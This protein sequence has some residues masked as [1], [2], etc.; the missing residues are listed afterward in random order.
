[1]QSYTKAEIEA[2]LADIESDLVERKATW[3]GDAPEKGRQAVCTFANDLPGHGKPGL[4]VVGAMD[5]GRPSGQL[6]SD[7]LLQTLADIKTDGNTLPPPTILVQK[8]VLQG[9]EMAVVPVT[10]A[11]TPRCVAQVGGRFAAKAGF[12]LRFAGCSWIRM[13]AA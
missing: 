6:V 12:K 5:D 13:P 11:D 7:R 10:P 3:E 1:M 4:L 8:M 9:A 2:M